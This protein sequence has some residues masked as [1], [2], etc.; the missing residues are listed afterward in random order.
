[1]VHIVSFGPKR[2]MTDVGNGPTNP[3]GPL[4][5]DVSSAQPSENIAPQLRRLRHSTIPE[6]TRQVEP[7]Q[8]LWIFE[9]QHEPEKDSPWLPIYA[10]S[11]LEFLQP[12]F[13]TMNFFTS[14]NPRSWFTT[15]VVATKSVMQSGIIVGTIGCH[16][17][18][19]K[20]RERGQKIFERRLKS[21]TERVEALEQHLGITLDPN[22]REAV[23]QQVSQI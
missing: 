17:D 23:K 21:E 14:Q 2:Y 18:Q 16:H 20:R 13:E 11:D 5:L 3:T 4:A 19:L 6:N 12:D 10:F 9:L 22:E 8:L 1:M 15:R 7:E